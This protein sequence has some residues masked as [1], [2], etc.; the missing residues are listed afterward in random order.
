M[1][2]I[3]GTSLCVLSFW[4]FCL[5]SLSALQTLY[6]FLFN[7]LMTSLSIP[8]KVSNKM[9]HAHTT[10]RFAITG[11]AQSKRTQLG[12]KHSWYVCFSPLETQTPNGKKNETTECGTQQGQVSLTL[13]GY[14]QNQVFSTKRPDFILDERKS[15]SRKTQVTARKA[16]TKKD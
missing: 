1:C 13:K 10:I 9:P 2:F 15:Y 16:K 3:R 6:S 14:S 4:T 12:Y 8:L 7:S 5:G 11:N